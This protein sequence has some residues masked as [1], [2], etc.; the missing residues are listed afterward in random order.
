[1]GAVA[2]SL[3]QLDAGI[4]WTSVQAAADSRPGWTRCSDLLAEP[5]RLRAW[6]QETADAYGGDAVDEGRLTGQGLVL[7]WY[8]AAVTL[9]AVGVFHLDRRVLDVAPERVLFRLVTAGAPVVA[10]AV[11]ST[12]WTG[13]VDDPAAGEQG[14][15]VVDD[16]G[17][18]AALLYETTV[19][20]AERLVTAYSTTTRIGSHGLWGAVTDAL[21]VAFLSGG[22]VSGDMARAAADARLV[23]GDGR[24]PLVG[25]STLHQIDD[26][27]GRRHWT[28]RRWSCCF[29]YR[30]P[31]V[32]ECVTCPRVDD[33]ERRRQAS[34][35]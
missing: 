19:G 23:L 6:Q 17:D 1:M 9:P 10:T 20:H 30:S 27:R 13:L 22:W 12:R 35:W 11:E 8:L 34:G 3:R 28:R 16:V 14:A 15:A 32:R 31:G 29:L 25:G 4:S 7:D 21:D 18:L 2:D 24:S 5:D 33:D 26:A